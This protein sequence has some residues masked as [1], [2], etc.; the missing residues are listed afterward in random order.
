[1]YSKLLTL[2]IALTLVFCFA[3]SGA[4]G[5]RLTLQ[6]ADVTAVPGDTLIAVPV[7]ILHPADTVAGIEVHF[8]IPNNPY[9]YFASDDIRA[10][11]I[12]VA[13]DTAGSM[14]S[15]WEWIGVSSL[16]DDVYD[17]KVAALADWPD[18]KVTGPA[19]PA[20]KELLVTLYF[21]PD[22]VHKIEETFHLPIDI[23]PEKT[24]FSDPAGNSIGILTSYE[25][26]CTQFVG[27]SCVSWKQMRVGTLDTIVVS[28]ENGSITVADTAAINK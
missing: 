7:Y 19:L 5:P 23:D 22:K 26:V 25:K 3:V 18:Q 14:L 4:E 9:L 13:A 2:A 10:D 6:V 17:L 11:G 27:D 12:L 1:M 15:K 8:T 20:E 28:Y 21:R 24:G 16:N